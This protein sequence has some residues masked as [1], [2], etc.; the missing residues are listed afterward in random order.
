MPKGITRMQKL[1]PQVGYVSLNMLHMSL[2]LSKT[3]KI[4]EESVAKFLGISW[5]LLKRC[6]M[7]KKD[8]SLWDDEDN[9]I[10]T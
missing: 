7:E 9:F 1:M 2:E 5:I 6:I 3:N 4:Y 10:M 8:I